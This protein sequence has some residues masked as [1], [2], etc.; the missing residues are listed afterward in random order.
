MYQIYRETWST[1]T[2][3]KSINVESEFLNRRKQYMY[4]WMFKIYNAT[5]IYFLFEK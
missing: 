3:T 2:K 1:L 5:Y 4:T